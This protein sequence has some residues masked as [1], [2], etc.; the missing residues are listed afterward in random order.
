MTDFEPENQ[1]MYTFFQ[2]RVSTRIT[3]SRR[4][5][6]E[7]RLTGAKSANSAVFLIKT[8]SN[9]NTLILFYVHQVDKN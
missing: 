3:Q 4:S 1:N 9:K 5:S 6:T 7:L 2:V 8:K